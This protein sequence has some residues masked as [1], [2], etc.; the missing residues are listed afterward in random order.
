MLERFRQ[1][2]GVPLD[3]DGYTAE[4][5][6]AVEAM[7]STFTKLECSQ[8]YAEPGNP[9]WEAFSAGRWDE[10]LRL[11]TTDRD[12]VHRAVQARGVDYRRVRVVT[13]PLTPYI[14]WEI[15]AF[16]RR[17]A[18][19]GEQIRVV[20]DDGAAGLTA[21]PELVVVDE[22]AAFEVLYDAA[23]VHSGARLVTEREAVSAARR[24]IVALFDRGVSLADFYASEVEGL[25][26]PR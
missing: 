14:Q 4:F 2:P 17:N 6:R 24:E 7:A 21:L 5:V 8:Q 22:T 25:P 26:P 1:L 19:L 18:P 13:R 11:I 10:A 16:V 23:G 12:I 3:P 9:S 15:N 20:V